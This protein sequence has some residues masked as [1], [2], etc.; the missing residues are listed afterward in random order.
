MKG[1]INTYAYVG[2]NPISNI[3][4]LGLWSITGGGYIGAGAELTVGFDNGHFFLTSRVGFG[5]GGGISVDPNGGVPGGTEATGN[6]GGAVISASVKA[7]AGFGPFGAG[8]QGGVYRNLASQIIDTFS[9][10]GGNAD[11]EFG[12]LHGGISGGV[13]VT[14]YTGLH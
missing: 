11:W 4:P 14:L 13:Q 6:C 2:G 1:G 7:D 5:I 9:E 3:D 8:Y 12:G 10:K